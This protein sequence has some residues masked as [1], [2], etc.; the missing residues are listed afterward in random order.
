MPGHHAD[1]ELHPAAALLGSL[2]RGNPALDRQA[3]AAPSATTSNGIREFAADLVAAMCRRL[4]E[5]GAPELHF[6]TLNLSKP[7]EA[8]IARL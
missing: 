1:L 7:T 2:R 6:Y 5:G 3:H 8:V 4:V